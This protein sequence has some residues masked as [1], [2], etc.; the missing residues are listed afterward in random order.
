MEKTLHSI[1]RISR[2]SGKRVMVSGASGL[3]GLALITA[4]VSYRRETAQSFEIHA[5]SRSG[6]FFGLVDPTE[7]VVHTGDL[8]DRP[9]REGLPDCEYVVHGATFGQPAKFLADKAS[10]MLLNSEVTIDLLGKCTERFLFLSTSEVYQGLSGLAP[11]ETQIGTTGPLH[12]RAVYIEAKRFG[13]TAVLNIPSSPVVANVARLSLAYG[14]GARIDDRRVLNE[15]IVR[16]LTSGKVELRGGHNLMRSY[17]F[18]D[19][20]VFYLLSILLRGKGEIYNVGGVEM[21]SLGYVAQAV[22]TALQLPYESGNVD[23]DESVGASP[24][25]VRIDMSKTRELCGEINHLPLEVG[26]M[27]TVDWFRASIS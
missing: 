14:P 11:V 15:L 1:P 25:E 8:L 10:T 7:I 17:V 2:L 13:E 27:K 22:A 12:S 23:Y 9:Y 6:E 20:A 4:L 19:D 21:H 5:L 26:I 24:L 16:G 18:I 3:V